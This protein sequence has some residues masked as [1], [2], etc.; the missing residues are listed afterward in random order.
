MVSFFYRFYLS[1]VAAR[2]FAITTKRFDYKTRKC[3]GCG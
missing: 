3:G 2:F 1:D